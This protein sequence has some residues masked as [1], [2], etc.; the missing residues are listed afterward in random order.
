MARFPLFIILGTVIFVETTFGRVIGHHPEQTFKN[1]WTARKELNA[2][3]I[4]STP[5]H[6]IENLM[7]FPMESKL[8]S[9][10]VNIPK[11]TISLIGKKT[12]RAYS[13]ISNSLS[14]PL[15]VV[16]SAVDDLKMAGDV[17]LQAGKVRSNRIR[18]CSTNLVT[19]LLDQGSNLGGLGILGAINPALHVGYLIDRSYDSEDHGDG[20]GM[21]LSAYRQHAAHCRRAFRSPRISESLAIY[22]LKCLENESV[23]ADYKILTDNCGTFTDVSLRQ[24]QSVLPGLPNV[25]LGLWIRRTEPSRTE[26]V[27]KRCAKIEA[28]L[29]GFFTTIGK[30]DLDKYAAI[31]KGNMDEFAKNH[32]ITVDAWLQYLLLVSLSKS[33]EIKGDAI[34]TIKKNHDWILEL[35][36]QYRELNKKTIKTEAIPSLLELANSLDVPGYKWLDENIPSVSQLIVDTFNQD[37]HVN[38]SE[39]RGSHLRNNISKVWVEMGKTPPSAE[40]IE[41]LKSRNQLS[42]PPTTWYE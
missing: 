1:L 36:Q 4:L 14:N 10:A 26:K 20:G 16:N 17:F 34:A 3:D 5:F 6:V 29:V 22:R 40:L 19:S 15:L 18:I 31:H 25:G 35:L 42:A 9:Q 11:A 2:N 7:Q 30:G 8:I 21:I 33:N 41:Y 38:N 24:C 32:F 12:K 27:Y 23:L 39:S 28:R 37:T 13:Q